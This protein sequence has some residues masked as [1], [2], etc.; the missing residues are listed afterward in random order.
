MR[1]ALTGVSN[2]VAKNIDKIKV[3]AHSFEKQTSGD[4]VLIAADMTNEDR[5]VLNLNNIKFFEVET[6]KNLTINDSRLIHT[7]NWIENSDYD[8]FMV[9]D[10][11]DV[12][13]QGDPFELMD[14]NSY[15][16]FAASEIVTATFSLGA[17]DAL[18]SASTEFGRSVM[19]AVP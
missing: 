7:A 12:C 2:N 10:V 9:T 13:F 14:F 1:K 17:L 5:N 4:A 3:W 8:L 19:T 16:F 11:F 15:D 6:D 18:R